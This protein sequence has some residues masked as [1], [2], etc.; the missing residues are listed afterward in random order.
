MI[1]LEGDDEVVSQLEIRYVPKPLDKYSAYRTASLIHVF[2]VNCGYLD[3]FVDAPSVSLPKQ[4]K[5]NCN[6]TRIQRQ[7]RR[8]ASS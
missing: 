5:H 7:Q 4:R 3:T 6:D 8:L 2:C 1:D